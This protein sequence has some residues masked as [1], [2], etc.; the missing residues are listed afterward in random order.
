MANWPKAKR[1]RTS[2]IF[3]TFTPSGPYRAIGPQ[4]QNS[5]EKRYFLVSWPP[6]WPEGS[7]GR[8]IIAV[9]APTSLAMH[10]NEMKCN[11]MHCNAL[12]WICNAMHCIAIHC[13]ATCNSLH[14]TS[15]TMQRF[16]SLGR[17]V[18]HFAKFATRLAKYFFSLTP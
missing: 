9:I 18:C 8:C 4:W 7:G 2:S 6:L 1:A 16:D 11:E 5:R 17:V 12:H 14:A 3:R 15:A 13:T 10:C